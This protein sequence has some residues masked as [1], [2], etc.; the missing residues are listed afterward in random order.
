[1]DRDFPA[2]DEA[3]LNDSAGFQRPGQPGFH[4]GRAQQRAGPLHLRSLTGRA[5]AAI[6]GGEVSF[7]DGSPWGSRNS[8]VRSGH[9]ADY[10]SPGQPWRPRIF[11]TG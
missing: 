2:L 3:Y 8:L 9:H 10:R 4:P 7:R 5:E 1:M 11:E 6:P